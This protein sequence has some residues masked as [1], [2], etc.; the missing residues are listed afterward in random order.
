MGS[1]SIDTISDIML[2]FLAHLHQIVNLAYE[3]SSNH[4]DGDSKKKRNQKRSRNTL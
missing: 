3:Y 2:D 4:R 1:F